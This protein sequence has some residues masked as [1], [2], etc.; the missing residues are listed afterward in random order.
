MREPWSLLCYKC[1]YFMLYCFFLPTADFGDFNRYDSQEF[2][3][4]F[5]LFPIVSILHLFSIKLRCSFVWIGS[6]T[7][8]SLCLCRTGF[9]MSECW[10]RPFRKWLFFISPSSKPD[11]EVSV[12]PVTQMAS[13]GNTLA[14]IWSVWRLGLL[15]LGCLYS[16]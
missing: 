9:R 13:R 11:F 3:Q 4:K 5:E 8:L 10:K 1:L 16:E 7:F 15:V 14:L 2:L 6:N 12:Y